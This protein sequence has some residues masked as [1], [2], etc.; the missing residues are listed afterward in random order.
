MSNKI[1]KQRWLDA[2]HEELNDHINGN[3]NLNFYNNIYNNIFSLLKINN[4]EFEDKTIIE[5]GP[6]LYPCLVNV[7]TQKSIVIEP[8]F[9]FFPPHIKSLY[10]INNIACI[11]Q[12][13]EEIED[14]LFNCDEIWV[15]NIMQHIIDPDLFIDKCIML[16]KII[17]IFEPIDCP[18]NNSHPHTY[19]IDYFLN[20]FSNFE[21]DLKIYKGN[22]IPNFHSANCVYGTIKIR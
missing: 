3:Y 6:A 11:T 4:N 17:R 16:S 22:S 5:V 19:S 20:K 7:K 9:D 12:P 13:L 1:T 15:F 18:T 2:Q 8:L 14:N 10:S 21:N